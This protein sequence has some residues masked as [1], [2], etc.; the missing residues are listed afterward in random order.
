MVIEN[1]KSSSCLLNCSVRQETVL[2]PILYLLY[3]A[4]LGDIM[5]HHGNLHHVYA[6]DTQIYLTFK[7]S[8]LGDM[9][10]PCEQVE[11]CVHDILTT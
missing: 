6:D 10:L 8:V 2:G 11:A 4:P 7:I 3:T 5:R 1:A 9:E